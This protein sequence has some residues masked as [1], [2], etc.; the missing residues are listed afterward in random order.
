M[1]T[2][3]ATLDGIA[4]DTRC[5]NMRVRKVLRGPGILV[6][7]AGAAYFSELLARWVID[8]RRGPPPAWDIT[9]EDADDK[10][11]ET[12]LV[13]LRRDGL[14]TMDARGAELH[15]LRP[16]VALGSG[17]DLAAGAYLACGDPLRAVEL[18][19]EEDTGSGA[20]VEWYP[21]K[22]GRK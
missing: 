19:A 20:P 15:S 21:F 8:G 2:I 22:R 7:S 11:H 14:H 10:A 3:L 9:Y 16:W 18:A 4:A 6:A 13:I 5:G 12:E 17:G 1:T